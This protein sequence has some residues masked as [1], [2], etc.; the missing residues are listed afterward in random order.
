MI[1][2]EREKK[3]VLFAEF[4]FFD[5]HLKWWRKPCDDVDDADAESL[6]P[7]WTRALDVRCV[8]LWGVVRSEQEK[9]RERSDIQHIPGPL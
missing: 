5:S 7:S 6:R 3:N 9:Q 4:V 1:Y 8:F 2:W